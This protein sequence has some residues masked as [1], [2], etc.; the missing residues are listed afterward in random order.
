MGALH[1]VNLARKRNHKNTTQ[2]WTLQKNL[3][4]AF[5]K[6]FAIISIKKEATN[7]IQIVLMSRNDALSSDKN[8]FFRKY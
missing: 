3:S 1:H 6:Y 5:C 4:L 8:L 2:I 7:K